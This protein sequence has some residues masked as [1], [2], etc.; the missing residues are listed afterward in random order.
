MIVGQTLNSTRNFGD[1]MMT[2]I[3]SIVKSVGPIIG[4][5]KA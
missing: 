3:S 5:K 1:A 4:L 2:G